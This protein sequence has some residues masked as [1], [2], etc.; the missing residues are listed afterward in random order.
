M[1][2]INK[3]QIN[4]IGL[5][6]V[7]SQMKILTPMG[8]KKIKNLEFFGSENKEKL[9]RKDYSGVILTVMS[10]TTYTGEGNYDNL[11]ENPSLFKVYNG[12]YFWKN[13]SLDWNIR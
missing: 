7:F 9:I 8:R 5:N 6:F 12:H 3:E 1:N 10:G 11:A 4:D 2:K 13:Y